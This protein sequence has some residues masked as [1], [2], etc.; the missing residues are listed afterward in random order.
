[1]IY[2]AYEIIYAWI[3]AW[4]VAALREKAEGLWR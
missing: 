2:R 1:M 3:K 4:P